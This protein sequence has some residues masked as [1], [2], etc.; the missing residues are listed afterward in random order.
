MMLIFRSAIIFAMLVIS[1]ASQAQS[2]KVDALYVFAAELPEQRA[3]GDVTQKEPE[4]ADPQAPDASLAL[5]EPVLTIHGI[6]PSSG[7]VRPGENQPC[8]T[9]L[10]RQEFDELMRIVAPGTKVNSGVRR[11][12]A[13]MYA[14]LL[15]FETAAR[16]SGI[17]DSPEFQETLQL[18]RLR[19]LADMYRRSLEK[20]YS[21]PS[22]QEID[23]YYQRET[24]RFEEVRLRRIVLPKSNFAAASKEEFEK[25]ALGLAGELR[26][27]AAKGEDLDQLQTEGYAKLGFTGPP[28]KTDAGNHRRA[29]LLD[30]VS[31]EIFSLNPGQVSKVENEPYSFVIYK[32]EAKHTLPE[33]LVSEEISRELSKKK[34]E[35]AL[36]AV[37][38][39][40]HSDLNEKYF[41]T[42]AG[43]PK[44]KP[45]GERS[46]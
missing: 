18:L 35:N 29:S 24:R 5:T 21:T 3:Q 15:A 41:G 12:V 17:P 37:T 14:E 42:S 10:T 25:K 7:N 11:N 23:E 33:E 13:Q 22:K 19:T 46:R 36:K 26:E 1:A 38:G 43:Q 44:I 2:P 45:A 30:E 34:L 8:T 9:V 16:R 28:P 32:I 39:S 27:R 40:I 31:D 20:D 4:R 6:C